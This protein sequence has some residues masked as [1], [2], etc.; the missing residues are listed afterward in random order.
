MK[1]ETTHPAMTPLV[2]SPEDAAD[3]PED[4]IDGTSGWW[5]STCTDTSKENPWLSSENAITQLTY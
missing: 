5:I 4:A 1:R 2:E 3:D